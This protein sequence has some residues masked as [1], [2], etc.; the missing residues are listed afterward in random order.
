MA[1]KSDNVVVRTITNMFI[2]GFHSLMGRNIR[3]NAIK[4]QNGRR[5]CVKILE[6]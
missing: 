1:M 5:E 2:G 6:S 3:I 4:I